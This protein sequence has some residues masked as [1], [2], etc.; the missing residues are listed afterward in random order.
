MTQKEWHSLHST[1][2]TNGRI[3]VDGK[4]YDAVSQGTI[5]EEGA[6][7]EVLSIESNRILVSKVEHAEHQQQTIINAEAVPVKKSTFE[8]DLEQSLGD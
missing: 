1:P 8:D 6:F 4:S 2:T 3:E 7:V 5:I